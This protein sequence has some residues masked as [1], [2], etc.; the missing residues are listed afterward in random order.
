MSSIGEVAKLL[1][2]STHTLRYYEKIGLLPLVDK[3]AGG[4][5]NYGDREIERVRFIKRAKRMHF[6]L[7]EIRT[8]IELD[9]APITEKPQVQR[10]VQD[11]LLEVEEG[12][13]DLKHLK[14]DLSKMLNACKAS[15]VEED[16]P[17]MEGIKQP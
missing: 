13:A 1:G 3:S 17:I 16:C 9:K 10:L 5:R 11:K 6:T 12:L 14:K 2:V 15:G 7:E 8:L 4:R